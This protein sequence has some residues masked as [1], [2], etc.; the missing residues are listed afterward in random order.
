MAFVPCHASTRAPSV[1][2]ATIKLLVVTASLPD[3]RWA[4]LVASVG[5]NGIA[6]VGAFPTAIVACKAQSCCKQ[7]A[8]VA[9]FRG[10]IAR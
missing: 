8:A 4:G 10:A 2:F 6:L 1:L 7:P 9:G 5:N 3:T